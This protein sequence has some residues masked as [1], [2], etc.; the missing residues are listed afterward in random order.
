MAWCR[1]EQKRKEPTYSEL[2]ELQR[3]LELVL[4]G[5]LHVRQIVLDLREALRE[6]FE[7]RGEDELDEVELQGRIHTQMK[8][9]KEGQ[10]KRPE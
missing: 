3:Q 4:N 10:E 1:S 7:Q 6:G 5:L 9:G 8:K 2:V